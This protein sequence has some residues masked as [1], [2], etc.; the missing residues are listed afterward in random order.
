MQ[1]LL[2]YVYSKTAVIMKG[3]KGKVI[4]VTGGA[5]S[6]GFAFCK[7]F[8]KEG[9]K[10]ILSDMDT[11]AAIE[12]SR[13]IGAVAITANVS[14]EADIKHLI[15]KTI[16]IYGHIDLFVSSAGIAFPADENTG[17]YK[18]D[19]SWDV[20]VMAHVYAARYVIPY[21]K[22]KG[23]GYLLNTVCA[24][25]LIQEFHSAPYMATK[26]A[27]LGFAEW[28]DTAYTRDGI[29]VSVLCPAGINTPDAKDI[30]GFL[31]D[32][33]EPDELVDLTLKGLA[34]EQF[35]ISTHDDS[36]VVPGKRYPL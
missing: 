11:T 25:G 22:Q 21:M 34:K 16:E 36:S 2:D 17:E 14:I 23:G 7:R 3:F 35:L 18:W 24:A 13:E 33:I 20:N 12:K 30:P 8:I 6:I 9:A 19:L 1:A 26:H 32:T 4:V 10:V 29:R 28:M 15:K 27:V 31:K 5:S